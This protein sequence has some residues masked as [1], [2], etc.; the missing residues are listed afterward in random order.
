MNLTTLRPLLRGYSALP[1]WE[2]TSCLLPASNVT[3]DVLGAAEVSAI[4]DLAPTI[5]DA[6][7]GDVVAV[8]LADSATPGDTL[9]VPVY[10]SPLTDTLSTSDVLTG[11]A[12]ISGVLTDSVTLV[13][14]INSG[15]FATF[16][17]TVTTTDTLGVPLFIAG[18]MDSASSADV[19]VGALS[20]TGV[21]A[22]S[23][24]PTDDLSWLWLTSSIDAA[25]P[26]DTF[27]PVSVLTV[28]FADTPTTTDTLTG[29]IAVYGLL[30]DS[31]A[32]GDT[33]S[34][35]MV[36]YGTLSD[37]PN[38]GDVLLT[39]AQRFFVVNADTKAVSEYTFTPTIQ[40]LG[41]WHNQL[42]LAT[43]SGLYALDA[44]TDVG[45]TINWEFR[46]GFSHL[47]TDRLK[48]VR[49]VNVLARGAGDVRLLLVSDRYGQKQENQYKLVKLTAD[50]FRDQVIKAGQGHQS[51]YWQLG[52]QGEGPAEIN[53][54][55]VAVEPLSRRR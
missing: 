29:V 38:A 43:S 15:I 31:L 9:S 35:Q 8:A 39:Q 54:L 21:F 55:R 51:V 7:I 49:D 33:L 17:D 45:A 44:D 16:V 28:G 11:T 41:T 24:T 2:D 12:S 5:L 52:C 30:S 6:L 19:I 13:D 36:L 10:I 18:L 20:L 23:Q 25:S 1:A 40:G 14:A 27:G 50:A 37:T 48:R 42:V 53:E 4:P 22:D 46:S 26:T 32:T 3:S 47:G 34:S